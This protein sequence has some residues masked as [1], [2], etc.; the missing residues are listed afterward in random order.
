MSIKIGLVGAGKIANVHSV[1]LGYV[2][3]V[4]VAAVCDINKEK[5][6]RFAKEHNIP[7]AYGSIEEMLEKESLDAVHICVWNI[8]HAKCAIYALEH[9]VNCLCEKPMAFNTAEAVEMKKAAEKSGKILMIGF[10]QRFENGTKAVKDLVDNG[11]AGEL[12]YARANYVRKHGNP[13]GWFCDKERSGGG[14]IIDLGVH[15]IDRSRY[16]MGSPMPVSVYAVAFNKLGNRP[17][18]KTKVGWHPEEATDNDVSTVEDSGIATI[19][20]D[21]GAVVVVE[22]SYDLNDEPK[23][24]LSLCGTKGGFFVDGNNIKFNSEMNGYL[25]DT[26]VDIEGLKGGKNEFV[27]EF[28]HFRDCILGKCECT[29]TAD[30]GIVCMK[31][32]DAIYESARTGHEVIIK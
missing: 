17:Y 23:S 10:V 8:N 6:E 18:I 11:Y 5:A 27:A 19:R 1:S 26:K 31:I 13:G 4:E 14:A 29:A 3:G 25:T 2:E 28:E 21:N 30:D 24:G 7:S 12:Y 9:G 32:L 20:Y 16:L 15:V 22:A